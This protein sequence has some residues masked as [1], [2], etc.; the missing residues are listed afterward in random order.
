MPR[1]SVPDPGSGAFFTLDPGSGIDFLGISYLG[2]QTQVV[3]R[4][5]PGS[6]TMVP[7]KESRLLVTEVIRYDL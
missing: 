7:R 2:S 5:Y 6:A 4:N 1:I 3:D